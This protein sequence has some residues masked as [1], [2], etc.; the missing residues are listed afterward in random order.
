MNIGIRR[1]YEGRRKVDEIRSEER[2][3]G[4]EERKK[5]RV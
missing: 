3:E 1:E 2:M 4:E 5:R